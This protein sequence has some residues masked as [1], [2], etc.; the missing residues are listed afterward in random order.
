MIV[1]D[2]DGTI[3]DMRY[4]TL[5]VLHTFDKRHN[6]GFF[7]HL[8]PEDISI[9][10]NSIDTLLDQRGIPEST[11]AKILSWYSENFWS[12]DA[13]FESHRPFH[14]V[15]DVIRWFQIQPNTY[16]GLNTGRPEHLREDTLRALN[17]LGAE[18]RVTFDSDLLFMNDGDGILT[19]KVK[20][21]HYFE[22]Q[23]FR[24]VA[25]V[26]NEPEN[27]S[28]IALNF[29]DSN[30]LLLHAHT[31]FESAATNPPEDAAVGFHYDLTELI[32]EHALPQHV[33]FV[34]HG[35]NEE[36]ILRQFLTSNVHV[37]ELHV[38]FDLGINRVILRRRSF[39]D[40]PYV[41]GEEPVRLEEYLDILKH[42]HRGVKLDIKDPGLFPYVIPTLKKIGIDSHEIWIS[43]SVD[44]MNRA[45]VHLIRKEFPHAI[46]QTPV[47]FLRT[48]LRISP[49]NA[50]RSLE[51]FHQWGIDRFS[52][53]WKSAE[54]RKFIIKLQHMGYDVNIYN[55]P[56][57]EAF[58]QA[59]LLLPTSLTSD[60]N[61][62]KW[63][64][65]GRNDEEYDQQSV[66]ME[67]IA[68][69]L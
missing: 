36:S 69:N 9:H 37:A 62:P 61:F 25:V 11:K 32:S 56:D 1:F 20:G 67:S 59:V 39:L 12:A 5:H 21:V 29:R 10:E 66:Y 60:F 45:M 64:Y 52:V 13:L 7:T 6:T 28:V 18:H 53:N 17:M 51:M 43:A 54:S 50:Y 8:R 46:L 19:G 41:S 57:L 3:L 65:H 40:Q 35:V 44:K 26:D 48:L 55:V 15:L 16:V 23:G 2:V 14:G 42:A 47:D 22:A 4:L 34:W 33:Q 38:R 58:L 49:R 63:F 31:I 27:L 68:G 30:I 24:V